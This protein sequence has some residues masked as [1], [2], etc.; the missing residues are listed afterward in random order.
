MGTE[1]K[2]QYLTSASKAL[3][4]KAG[5]LTTGGF[6]WGIFLGKFT[7]LFYVKK[8]RLKIEE[9]NVKF[10]INVRKYFPR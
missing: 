3:V 8:N 5:F 2:I 10:Q 7:S 6:A 4:G 1:R 9:N